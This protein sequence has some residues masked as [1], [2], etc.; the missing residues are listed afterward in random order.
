MAAEPP[1]D[2]L[3]APARSQ[4]LYSRVL[5]RAP[6][7]PVST[8]LVV[9][10]SLLAAAA[11]WLPDAGLRRFAVGWIAVFLLPGVVAALAT[12]PLAGALGGRFPQRRSALLSLSGLVIV[13]PL[14]AI[15]WVLAHTVP[16]YLPSVAAIA[17]FLQAPV[18]WFRHMSLYGVSN[19]HHLRSL[20]PSLL[21]PV[22][23]MLGVFV[24]YA[25]TPALVVGAGLF[26]VI[27]FLCAALLLRAADRP[28]RREFGVS[29]VSMIRPL[30][31][32]IN[33]RQSAA[34]EELEGFFAKFAIPAKLRV[35]LISFYA[36]GKPKATVALPTV[37]P[38]PFAALG[39]SDL[40]HKL[41]ERLLGVAGTLFVPHT[42]C[43]HDLDLPTGADVSR[44]ADATRELAASAPA[45]S[46]QQAS[47]LV[48][49]RPGSL[50]RAQMLGDIALV[51]VS[52]AP[53]PT[54]D[55]AFAVVD[56]LY[57]HSL[58]TGGPTLAFIDAHNSY[59]EGQGDLNYG[60]PAAEQLALD[61]HSAVDLAIASSR[62]GVVRVGAA[63]RSGYSIGAQGIG[64]SGIRA[65]VIEAAG[66]R[67]AYVLIDGNNLLQGLRQPI[68]DGLWE[69]VDDAEVM[70]TDNHV[71]HEVDG[72]INPV[73]ERFPLG[74]LRTE[75]RAAVQAAVA[76]LVE[77]AV[78]GGS[79]DIPDVAVL[80]PAW[81]VRLLTSLGDTLSMFQN[82][83]L[84]TFLLL[85]TSSLVVLVAL[86]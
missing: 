68:L 38:G 86:R 62:P 56:Q 24:L 36:G 81:T 50:A 64:P 12:G 37:H 9:L 2:P 40:P 6:S 5:F 10:V 11:L 65:L 1:P 49:P 39:A 8:L 76:D 44:V 14:A 3:A 61:V 25:P 60:T 57:R 84:T 27:A 73:G 52:Q 72:G 48:S 78:R 28:L 41:E 82:A 19:P 20:P 77:V 63:V 34:T 15:W 75:V 55:I 45:A 46:R 69:L 7:P 59:V 13:V 30:L 22:F 67:A 53:Q 31:D 42:P 58:E 54:D 23:G 70:T 66:R 16:A 79:R 74:A 80:Q 18:L 29:G 21:Q 47:P 83:F 32:H 35:T 51:L 33:E 17:L 71:V 4:R 26:L 43:N 85:M